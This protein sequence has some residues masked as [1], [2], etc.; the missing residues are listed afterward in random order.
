MNMND[1]DDDDYVMIW[2]ET[3]LEYFKVLYLLSCREVKETSVRITCKAAK[4]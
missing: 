2:N 1:D 3:V 4:C